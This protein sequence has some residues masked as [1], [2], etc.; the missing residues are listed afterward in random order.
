VTQAAPWQA[1]DSL[2]PLRPVDRSHAAAGR[3]GTRFT[4]A[5]E[6][7]AALRAA[8][9]AKSGKG[10]RVLWA[11]AYQRVVLIAMTAGTRLAEH[12]SPPAASFHVVRGSARLYAAEP[13]ADG[14]LAEWVAGEGQV[15]AIPPQRHG[16]EAVDDC[17]ILLTVSLNPH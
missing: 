15:V 16:V 8:R 1:A 12:A 9:E 4:I 2:G 3:Q 13:D 7:G 6:A 5:E 10:T 14:R 11:T 17:V